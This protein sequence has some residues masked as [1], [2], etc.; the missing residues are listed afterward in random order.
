MTT[1]A[2]ANDLRTSLPDLTRFAL[3][4]FTRSDLA[5]GA[6]VLTPSTLSAM[7]EPSSETNG[8]RGLGYALWPTGSGQIIAG[9]D[10]SASMFRVSPETGDGIVL[11]SN[12]NAY[13]WVSRIE[14]A[15]R[16]WAFGLGNGCRA[17]SAHT[18]YG[19][20]Q[21]GGVDAAV[22]RFAQLRGAEA[23]EYLVGDSQLALFAHLLVGAGRVADGGS[24][25]AA[26]AESSSV[27]REAYREVAGSL[28]RGEQL[29]ASFYPCY[30]ARYETESGEVVE[31]T[32]RDTEL[33]LDISD[34]PWTN[35]VRPLSRRV[36]AYDPFGSDGETPGQI[37][38]DLDASG[39]AQRLSLSDPDLELALQASRTSP[40]VP[41]GR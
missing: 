16:R 27:H 34:L 37:V 6:G 13:M 25:F 36:F 39:A 21:A 8:R 3:S 9:H 26:L 29:E 23:E 38:F 41:C 19:A 20:Y 33:V 31:L 24:V 10:G 18:L 4:H 22:D 32:L 7:L 30:A 40:S 12:S 15:W 14:C 2:T 11:V 1:D 35:S 5:K 17:P 28:Q